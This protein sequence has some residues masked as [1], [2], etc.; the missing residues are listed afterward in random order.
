MGP[1]CCGDDSVDT[2]L[3]RPIQKNKHESPLF[4]IRDFLIKSSQVNEDIECYMNVSMM[5]K[6]SYQCI[7]KCF[8]QS[9]VAIKFL[10]QNRPKFVATFLSRF[11]VTKT[12]YSVK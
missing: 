5:K 3:N 4:Q 9:M 8:D 2:F 6:L 10:C 7:L 12:R 1:P 11:H